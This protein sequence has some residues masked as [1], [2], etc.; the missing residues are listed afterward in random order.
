MQWLCILLYT[1]IHNFG[2]K[3]IYSYSAYIHMV[4][5]YNY[6]FLNM[7]MQGKCVSFYSHGSFLSKTLYCH[8]SSVNME[9]TSS[10]S[11]STSSIF[12]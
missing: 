11:F 1:L 10:S 5:F 12:F 3:C 4:L 6:K 8:L 2:C 9:I 7:G